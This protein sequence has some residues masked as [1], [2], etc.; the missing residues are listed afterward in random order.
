MAHVSMRGLK[1]MKCF[2]IRTCFRETSIS[3]IFTFPQKVSTLPKDLL[4]EHVQ[5]ADLITTL[6]IQVW[7]HETKAPVARLS[8][9]DGL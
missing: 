7:F 6:D 9:I 4:L 2:A 3:W 5:V 8:G 1:Q